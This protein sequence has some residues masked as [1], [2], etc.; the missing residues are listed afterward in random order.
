METKAVVTLAQEG[1]GFSITTVALTLRAKIPNIDNAK[2]QE[3]AGTAKANCPVS[4][5]FKAE[6]TLDAQLT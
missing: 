5:L 3:L 1:E 6:I 4:K 2:F